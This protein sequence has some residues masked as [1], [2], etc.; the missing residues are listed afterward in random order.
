MPQ[1]IRC[2]LFATIMLFAASSF[3]I[4]N[5][6]YQS[7][8][9]KDCNAFW[10]HQPHNW[11][12]V[13]CEREKNPHYEME[14]GA[15]WNSCLSQ[16]PCCKNCFACCNNSRDQK[17]NCFCEEKP[18]WMVEQCQ[19]A[20][21]TRAPYCRG[22]CAGTFGDCSGVSNNARQGSEFLRWCDVCDSNVPACTT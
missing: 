6:Q 10:H 1:T 5:A 9:S 21:N 20:A 4:V 19:N 7:D 2:F 3:N 8:T 13:Q 12:P 22:E 16:A 15:G 14:M 11:S 17:V 18:P